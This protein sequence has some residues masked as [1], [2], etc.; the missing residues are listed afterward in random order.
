MNKS[1]LGGFLLATWVAGATLAVQA[2]SANSAGHVRPA[3]SD[4]RSAAP[5]A[6][7]VASTLRPLPSLLYILPEGWQ[8]IF[9]DL[10]GDGATEIAQRARGTPRIANNLLRR[11]R[12][13]A[14]VR[15]DGRV[16]REIADHAL[17]RM[18]VDGLGLDALDRAYLRVI[19][20]RFDGGPVGI[21]AV[22]ASLGQ[23][24]D[25][26]E[27][28]IEP[29]LVQEGFIARTPRGETC[30]LGRGGSDTSGALLAPLAGA[31]QLEIWAD[32]HGMF[33]SD[34]RRVPTARLIRRIG[35]REAQELAA[36]GARV[37]H[38]RCLGPVARAG[39]PLTVRNTFDPDAGGTRIAEEAGDDPSV[40]AVVHMRRGLE[41]ILGRL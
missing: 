33:T 30:L 21:E 3:Y 26:L 37:L 22:A 18:D 39:I 15:G 19:V 23:E 35:Y 24:R 12:D 34:P 17:G 6:G 40:T 10:D 1:G 5:A 13:F 27:D 2:G 7:D 38:P 29:Y 16:T 11:V 36:L 14:E 31:E 20:E 32:V 8:S 28:W 41:S 4:Q 9:G 25:T